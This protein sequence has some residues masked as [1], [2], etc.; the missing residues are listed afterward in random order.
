M[1]P[2]CKTQIL[3]RLSSVSRKVR[4]QQDVA[5]LPRRTRRGFSLAEMTLVLIVTAMIMQTGIELATSHTKRQI[6]QRAAATMSAVSDDIQTYMDR[7]YFALVATLNA[8]PNNV[9]EQ[10][11]LALI[12]TNLVSLD[13]VP[14][15]PDGGDMRLFFTLRG[16]TVYSVVMSF[17]GTGSKYAPKPDANTRFAGKV[18]SI[19]PNRLNGWDFSLPIPEIATLTG[20]DLNGNIGVIRQVA[21]D[22][23]VNPYLHRI[24][25]PGR[26][27]LNSMEANLDLGGFN[28]DNALTITTL[29]LEVQDQLSVAGSITAS[30]ITSTGDATVGDIIANNVTS[31]EVNA[32]NASLTGELNTNTAAIRGD[33]VTDSFRGNNASFGNL[34]ATNFTGGSVFLSTGN[35]IQIDVSR[36]DADLV[37]ADQVFIGD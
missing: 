22:V 13:E 25:V 18:Q 10:D 8:A 29:D 5:N 3:K 16:D 11:W 15:S 33:L 32:N 14:L 36:I 1:K 24:A 9:I 2:I 34:S 28:I 30:T 23:N 19:S 27:D 4:V 21:L 26:P 6:T 35:Y 12:N 20:E 7:N 31:T 17:D 37:I